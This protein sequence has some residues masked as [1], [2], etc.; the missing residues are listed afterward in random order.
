MLI[1]RV[2]V[3]LLSFAQDWLITFFGPAAQLRVAVQRAGAGIPT[4][5][6]IVVARRSETYGSVEVSHR[7]TET[8][9]S[10]EAA[11]RA[12]MVHLGSPQA[13][14]NDA[15][16]VVSF[17]LSAEATEQSFRLLSIL[18]VR[19]LIRKRKYEHDE[20]LLMLGINSENVVADTLGLGRFV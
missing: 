13:F 4:Q 5:D 16:I 1:R 18:P 20:S 12:L 2:Y 17:V 10:F 3:V 14:G 9:V 19:E 6:G 15:G 11:A 7:L 8:L